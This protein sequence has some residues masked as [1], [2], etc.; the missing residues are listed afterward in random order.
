MARKY[1]K[2]D[3]DKVF[4]TSD[5]HFGH[6]KILDF[7][8]RGEFCRTI[9]E[10]D[11]YVIDSWN[12]V[13]S[14]SDN[15]FHLGDFCFGNRALMERILGSLN[16]HIHVIL[17]NHDYINRMHVFADTLPADEITP[18]KC[19]IVDS[20]K[21]ELSH[22]PYLTWSGWDNGVWNLHGHLHST[23]SNPYR[24]SRRNQYDVGIDNNG[25]APVSFHEVQEIMK[26]L[27]E[28]WIENHY[29][30]PSLWGRIKDML[31]VCE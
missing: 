25:F 20:Q 7:T 11:E 2:F 31:S 24:D 9:E 1:D 10:H 18:S 3:G 8:E 19:V 15:V 28:D 16:G 30:K 14:N 13:V 27:D 26:G 4:F 29:S 21:I 6:K 5:T 23:P 12:N 22:Y 17:G